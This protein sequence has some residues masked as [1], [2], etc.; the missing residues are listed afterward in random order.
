MGQFFAQVI[1]VYDSLN[2][3]SPTQV[4]NLDE[5]GF[6]LGRG[7]S[8]RLRHL[9]MTQVGKRAAVPRPTFHYQ[10]RIP[11]LAAI[12]ASGIAVTPAVVFRGN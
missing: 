4:C 12:L 3:I 1:L 10:H 11:V 9:V 7:F 5:T 6:T 2:I 8:G